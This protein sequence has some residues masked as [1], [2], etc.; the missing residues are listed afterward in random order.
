MNLTLR[1][2]NLIFPTATSLERPLKGVA[3]E[4]REGRIPGRLG[5]RHRGR[6]RSGTQIHFSSGHFSK[7]GSWGRWQ[8]PGLEADCWVDIPTALRACP[9]LECTGGGLPGIFSVHCSTSP[10][11]DLPQPRAQCTFTLLL[12]KFANT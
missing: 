10:C 8:G 7:A 4:R 12:W 5:Y 11:S 1:G 9:Q 2:A 3:L 6:K